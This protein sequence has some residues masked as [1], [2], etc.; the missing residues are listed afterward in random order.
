MGDFRLN[1]RWI[2]STILTALMLVQ[3]VANAQDS[4]SST[5]LGAKI[6]SD[7]NTLDSLDAQNSSSLG[8]KPT[9]FPRIGYVNA[10][11]LMNEA[12]QGVVAFELIVKNFAGRKAELEVMETKLEQIAKELE[13]EED[14]DNRRKLEAE[15]RSLNREFERGRLDY[16]EDFNYRRNDELTKLQDFISEVILK[17]AKDEKFDLIVQEPVV[18]ASDDI[19]ITDEILNKLHELHNTPESQ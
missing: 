9:K 12:P 13:S 7:H 18:W 10:N 6:S 5:N 15:F 4:T 11:V 3:Y 14:A 2:L 19:D 17:L 16:E 1:L 8:T